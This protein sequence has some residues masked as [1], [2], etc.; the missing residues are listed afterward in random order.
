M[1]SDAYLVFEHHTPP[2][3]ATRRRHS[4]SDIVLGECAGTSM[5]HSEPWASARRWR[6][7]S[8]HYV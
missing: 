2:D 7:G 6:A 8:R 3:L 5:R 4:S 1:T